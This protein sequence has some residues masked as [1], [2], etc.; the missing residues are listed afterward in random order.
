MGSI[1]TCP[2]VAL[3]FRPLVRF[4][5]V[6]NVVNPVGPEPPAVYWRRR[7]LVGLAILVALIVLLLLFKSFTGGSEPT[8]APVS[9]SSSASASSGSSS[10]SPSASGECEDADITVVAQ[11]E[12]TTVKVGQ[13]VPFKMLITNNSATP[14]NRNVGPKVNTLTVSS[15]GVH[16][17]SSDDCSPAG[18]DQLE[19]IPAGATYGVQATWDQKLTAKGCPSGLGSAQAGGYEVVAENLGVKSKPAPFAIE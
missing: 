10:A 14:C 19:T 16:A 17:W 11:P 7:L 6:S 1:V 9:P 12:K 2:P 4:P 13:S 15:G 18:G 8:A 5:C 3:L